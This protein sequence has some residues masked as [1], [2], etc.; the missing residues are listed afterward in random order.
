MGHDVMTWGDWIEVCLS[1]VWC[2][3]IVVSH[4]YDEAANMM[5]LNAIVFD[6]AAPDDDRFLRM[7]AV[8]NVDTIRDVRVRLVH[9]RADVSPAPSLKRLCRDFCRIPLYGTDKLSPGA[10]RAK[11]PPYTSR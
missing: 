3:G 11:F 4:D 9:D 8:L 7:R 10:F 2:S 5:L 1:G 6:P